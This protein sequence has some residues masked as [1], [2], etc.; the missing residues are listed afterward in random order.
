MGMFGGGGA[1]GGWS[2]SLT[3]GNHGFRRGMDGWNDDELGKL[4]D[5][6]VVGRD[7]QTDLAVVQVSESDVAGI[8]PITWADPKSIVV[9]EPVVAIGYALDISGEPTVTSGVVS[10]TDR[11]I[12]EQNGVTISGS[13]QTDAAI[14]PGNSGGPL[15]DATGP[16]IAI[17]T[18]IAPTTPGNTAPGLY[19][20]NSSP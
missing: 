2:Q 1:A 13:V 12:D 7:P 11:I 5:A 4:Y 15:L 14:N 9:G 10:A 17:N 19:P 3:S 16:V 8:K 20:S 6:K 18:A